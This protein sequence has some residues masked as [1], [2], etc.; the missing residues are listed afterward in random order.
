M[1]E[2]KI[3]P[4]LLSFGQG[5]RQFRVARNCNQT[6]V[7]RRTSVSRSYVGLVETGRTRC[8]RDFATRLDGALEARGEIVRAW[9]EL[10]QEFK[11]AR[12]AAH[13][14]S[15]PR[16]EGTASMLRTFEERLVYGLFQTEAYASALLSDESKV[17]ARMKRQE[18]LVR[19]HP[20]AIHSVMDESILYREVGNSKTMHDQLE[21]LHALSHRPN[22]TIQ[23]LPVVYVRNLWSCFAIATQPDQKELGYTVKAYGGETSSDPNDLAM[24]NETFACLQAEAHNARDTR[25]LIRRAIDDRWN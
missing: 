24:L 23:L 6:E 12:Y 1:P 18:R 14:G 3:D 10:L 11:A 8:R 9:D 13:F 2:N 17:R 4:I 22:I 19:E 25:S 21:F 16:A 7:A 5:V 20:P 15:F